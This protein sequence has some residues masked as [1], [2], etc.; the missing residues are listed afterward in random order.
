MKNIGKGL[1]IEKYERISRFRMALGTVK[2]VLMIISLALIIALALIMIWL[3]A[4]P[5]PE[6]GSAETEEFAKLRE[7]VNVLQD[8]VQD[9]ALGLEE[10]EG[11][12]IAGMPSPRGER[13]G[14][15]VPSATEE[16]RELLY[17]IVAGEARGEPYD[18]M[19]A[20]AETVLN[21]AR[22]WDMTPTEIMTAEG[23]FY[24]GYN[25]PIS[26]AVKLAVSDALAGIKVFPGQ[27]ITHFH[28]ASVTPYWA[29][30]KTFVGKIGNHKFYR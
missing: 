13:T 17:Q 21:R 15:E 27:Q 16:E 12:F 29:E 8:K 5:E 3:M 24:T 23:Q 4:T 30:S 26:D 7:N 1:T 28:E 6:P 14:F 25:G 10:A 11:L 19:I 18:G 22:L 9:L 20:V 2:E